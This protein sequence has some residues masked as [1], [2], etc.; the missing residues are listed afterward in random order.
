MPDQET[1]WT[2]GGGGGGGRR[3]E[4]GEYTHLCSI[5]DMGYFNTASLSDF[6]GYNITSHSRHK[7]IK[8][9]I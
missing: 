8:V 3:V 5:P 2:K 1:I 9:G 7:F 6:I 4:T